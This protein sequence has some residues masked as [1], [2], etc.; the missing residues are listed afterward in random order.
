LAFPPRNPPVEI[1][2]LTFDDASKVFYSLNARLG[3]PA[4]SR[5]HLRLPRHSKVLLSPGCSEMDEPKNPASDDT[6]KSRSPQQVPKAGPPLRPLQH[7]NSTASSTR[8]PAAEKLTAA[9]NKKK[10]REAQDQFHWEISQCRILIQQLRRNNYNS[11]RFL[12]DQKWWCQNLWPKVLNAVAACK[13]AGLDDKELQKIDEVRL[14]LDKQW[15]L[16]CEEFGNLSETTHPLNHDDVGREFRGV[17]KVNPGCKLSKNEDAV[18]RA[19]KALYPDGNLDHKATV[20][21]RRINK[22]LLKGVGGVEGVG[23]VGVN[24]R[25]IQRALSKIRVT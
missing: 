4:E 21:D 9:K 2:C 23:E 7:F 14:D 11:E 1:G 12:F 24:S 10:K 22:V 17:W 13:G 6:N 15:R 18:F 8:A 25:T 16:I 19:V 5:M 3:W 20:R